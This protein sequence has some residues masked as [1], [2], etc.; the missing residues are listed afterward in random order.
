MYFVYEIGFYF[1]KEHFE[2]VLR[3]MMEPSGFRN[4]R[5]RLLLDS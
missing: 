2:M 1:L 5:S 3:Y 4:G